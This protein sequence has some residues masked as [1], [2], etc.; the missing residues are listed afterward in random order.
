[1]PGR[2]H[3][4]AAGSK[5][6][7][8]GEPGKAS[9]VVLKAGAGGPGRGSETPDSSSQCIFHARL[10][11]RK[12]TGEHGEALR[13]AREASPLAVQRLIELMHPADDRVSVVASNAILDR[14]LGK[15]KETVPPA[16]LV[17]P[18]SQMRAEELRKFLT[19]ALDAKEQGKMSL[20]DGALLV[21]FQPPSA[22]GRFYGPGAMKP[23]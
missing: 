22:A 8:G 1:M 23:Q 19:A 3:H 4:L 7:T 15:P 21:L 10:G 18:E 20:L 16:G 17:T 6:A 14:S 5:D 2:A 9:T 11:H 12:A 13:L